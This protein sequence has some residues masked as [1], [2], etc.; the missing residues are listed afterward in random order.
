MYS[1]YSDFVTMWNIIFWVIVIYIV[2]V[3]FFMAVKFSQV[4]EEKGY[5]SGGYFLIV[6]FCGIFGM[7]YIIALPDR[8]RRNVVIQETEKT[9]NKDYEVED[10]RLPDL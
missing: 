1:S 10:D 5:T 9:K 4:A 8:G 7:L 6:L 2:V 3:Q